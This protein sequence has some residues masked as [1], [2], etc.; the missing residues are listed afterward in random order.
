MT[1]SHKFHS[2][3]EVPAGTTITDFLPAFAGVKNEIRIGTPNH[4]CA[5]CRKPFNQTRK[6]RKVVRIAATSIPTPIL[7]AFHICG[8]CF[9]LH[10]EGGSARESF[11]VAVQAYFEGDEAT[12]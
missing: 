5:C 3:T 6:R 7:F 10:Q 8:R 4:N 9:A 11:M 12:Q 1:T 2:L